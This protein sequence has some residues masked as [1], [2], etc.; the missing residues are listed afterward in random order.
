MELIQTPEIWVKI[1]FIISFFFW[2]LCPLR[3]SR[4]YFYGIG[5]NPIL[6]PKI[7]IL[8]LQI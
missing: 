8:F 5:Q 7:L 3:H 2:D 6:F 4:I 1:V